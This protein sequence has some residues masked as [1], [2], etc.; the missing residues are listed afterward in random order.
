MGIWID[1]SVEDEIA[2]DEDEDDQEGE[3]D[4]DSSEDDD[5]QSSSTLSP[6]S[7]EEEDL[8][9]KGGEDKAVLKLTGGRSMFSAL[10]VDDGDD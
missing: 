9:D 8:E 4:E 1:G 6:S 7:D 2:G 3:D 10:S 5:S